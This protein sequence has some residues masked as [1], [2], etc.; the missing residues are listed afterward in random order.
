[1]YKSVRQ[2]CR[3]SYQTTVSSTAMFMRIMNSHFA[4]RD[5]NR[6]SYW[7]LSVHRNT[8]PMETPRHLAII[9]NL[10]S[11]L[12]CSVHAWKITCGAYWMWGWLEKTAA[13]NLRHL[14]H[15]KLGGG[16]SRFKIWRPRIEFFFSCLKL[17]AGHQACT[18][19]FRASHALFN[20]S[21]T[22][23]ST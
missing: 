11:G 2:R 10:G 19:N 8:K 5:R 13:I 21:E 18:Y 12:R 3:L 15:K 4:I 14:L 22:D 23:I 9:V 7:H 1:M 16:Q 17:R 6:H 20:P